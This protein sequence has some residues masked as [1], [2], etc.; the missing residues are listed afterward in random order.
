MAEILMPPGGQTTDSSVITKW[1]KKEGDRVKRGDI[2]LSVETDKATLDIESFAAG[3]LVKCI[4]KEGDTAQ[5]G[6]VVAVIETAA[7]SAGKAVQAPETVKAEIKAAMPAKTAAAFIP[8]AATPPKTDELKILA[9]PLAKSTAREN[10]IDINLIASA[11]GVIKNADILKYIGNRVNNAATTGNGSFI[12]IDVNIAALSEILAQ[13][14][15]AHGKE[16]SY[17]KYV[18]KAF[19]A[20]SISYKEIESF[21]IVAI[22]KTSETY[23]S[24]SAVVYGNAGREVIFGFIAKVKMLTD[25]ILL[26]LAM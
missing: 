8:Q 22:G 21:E 18:H 6:D 17:G 9:S 11:D 4:F 15:A 19:E 20:A 12:V 1:H 26:L 2:L 5:T 25:N 13:Y 3:V 10:N 7:A 23:A 14:K 16:L 24:V